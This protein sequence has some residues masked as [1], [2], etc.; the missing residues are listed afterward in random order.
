M[1]AGKYFLSPRQQSTWGQWALEMTDFHHPAILIRI[2]ANAKQMVGQAALQA[3]GELSAYSGRPRGTFRINI[4]FLRQ[5]T[6][7][8]LGT[9]VTLIL[10]ASCQGNTLFATGSP[11]LQEPAL[12]A[13]HSQ[14][15]PRIWTYIYLTLTSPFLPLSL[16]FFQTLHFLPYLF[17]AA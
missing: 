8:E 9:T 12:L 14:R 7:S 15:Y 6:C 4:I 13:S 11:G 10:R 5:S 16:L 3:H 2:I 17:S 1:L